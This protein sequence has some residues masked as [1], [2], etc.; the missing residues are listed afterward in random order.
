MYAPS[1]EPCC[2]SPSLRGSKAFMNTRAEDRSPWSAVPAALLLMALVAL[3][4]FA[5]CI[6]RQ[7]EDPYGPLEKNRRIFQE[8]G[9]IAPLLESLSDPDLRVRAAAA[10]YLGASGDTRAIPA[11]EACLDDRS[12]Y[13][14]E[15]AASALQ[16]L[17]QPA[18]A[19]SSMAQDIHL[20]DASLLRRSLAQGRVVTTR[21]NL[22]FLE[23]TNVRSID[24]S[25]DGRFIAAGYSSGGFVVWDAV[26]GHLY[27]KRHPFGQSRYA[28]VARYNS[29]IAFSR[30]GKAFALGEGGA[31][32][33]HSMD[34]GLLWSRPDAHRVLPGFGDIGTTVAF[35]PLASVLVSGGRDGSVRLWNTLG[36]SPAAHLLDQGAPVTSLALSRDGTRLAAGDTEGVIRI[37]DLASRSLF[38]SLRT[39][40]SEVTCIGFTRDGRRLVAGF[41]DGFLRGWDVNSG[42]PWLDLRGRGK[43]VKTI[44]FSPDGRI[45]A[46]GG[47]DAVVRLWDLS[48]GTRLSRLEGHENW[49]EAA[50]FAPD[51]SILAT[52]G[53]DGTLRLW[54][55]K[56]G[57]EILKLVNLQFTDWLAITPH[58][59]INAPL[60]AAEHVQIGIETRRYP[61]DL[62][63]SR[64]YRP[65]AI[66]RSLAEKA[67]LQSEAADPQA[68]LGL[69]PRV[70]IHT[71]EP[72]R[73]TEKDRISIIVTAVDT[74]GGIASMHL[75]HNGR[76][77]SQERAER[78]ISVQEE[79]GRI[80]RRFDVSLAVGENRFEATAVSGKGVES[81]RVERVIICRRP[82]EETDLHVLAVGIDTYRNAEL[83][84]HHAEAD[85]RG[86]AS[87][88]RAGRGGLFRNVHVTEM[89]NEKATAAAIRTALENL[90][91]RCR[92]QDVV[93]LYLCGHGETLDRT[94]FFLP[95]D[96]THPERE[97]DLERLG[98]SSDETARFLHRVRARKVLLVMDSCKS[99]AAL[100]SFRGIEDRRAL[101][102]LARATGVYV[103][104]ASSRDQSAAEVRDL[105]HGLFT[106]ALLQGLKGEAQQGSRSPITVKRLLAYVEEQ[107][108]LLS[109]KHRR[110]PQ[111][112]VVYSRGMD[113][114][115]AP[116]R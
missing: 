5:A 32:E 85:A 47:D 33:M 70:E 84:L 75:F 77:V 83:N 21:G 10:A 14:R 67:P 50:A 53:R 3:S 82:A 37:W 71:R 94:W 100:V 106:Y 31:V 6:P 95:H 1:H 8:T 30:D 46:S 40:P 74:G 24:F 88:F 62:L 90:V 35:S 15:E 57:G 116:G 59:E 17:G 38:R 93:M 34:G 114:P 54:N 29:S 22:G 52:G 115:L 104:A 51:G 23:T 58:G 103:I 65:E 43:A 107:L 48:S 78:G 63:F 91:D 18:R 111:Y 25:P 12:R 49:V 13:V 61:L 76:N 79:P 99:G 112:P 9:E 7:G 55:T 86:V 64:C 68:D 36:G 102:Q 92:P 20:P 73:E 45:M 108:P 97:E 19:G 39:G 69:P 101:M 28:R 81:Q 16:A 42:T 89:L 60:D 44:A 96:L 87:F 98:I 105:G 113:F 4:A 66:R 27:S 109:L 2:T 110:R 11:L 41:V 80:T 56:S 72:G 26:E